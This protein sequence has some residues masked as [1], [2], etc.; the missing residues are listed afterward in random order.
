MLTEIL[1][2]WV[3]IVDHPL[4]VVGILAIVWAIA[5]LIGAVVVWVMSEHADRQQEAERAKFARMMQA[6]EPRTWPKPK[7]PG[8]PSKRVS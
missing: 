7:A 5:S 4:Q 6:C 3:W 1:H 2:G 8:Y